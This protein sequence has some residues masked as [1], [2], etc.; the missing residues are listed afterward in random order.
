M[1]GEP[2]PYDATM[3]ALQSFRVTDIVI[4][5]FPETKSGWLRADLI[6][7]VR[8]ASGKPVEHVVA[9]HEPAAAD[10]GAAMEAGSIAASHATPPT[11]TTTTRTARPPPTAPRGSTPRRWGCCSSSSRRS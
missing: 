4:S 2:D 11:R 3:N 9:E 5:T 8:S 6:E 1:I 7:R 10:L